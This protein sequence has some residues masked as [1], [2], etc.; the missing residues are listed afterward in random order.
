MRIIESWNI[1]RWKGPRKITDSKSWSCMRTPT[2]PP[3]PESVVQTLPELWHSLGSLFSA[4]APLSTVLGWSPLYKCNANF[5]GS[6]LHVG[7]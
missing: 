5:E 6:L 7:T 3:L 4:S 1:L 2:M